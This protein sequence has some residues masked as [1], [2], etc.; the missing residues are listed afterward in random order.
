MQSPGV[1]RTARPGQHSIR[2]IGG[3]IGFGGTIAHAL[4]SMAANSFANSHSSFGIT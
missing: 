4:R 2:R 3:G 1:P